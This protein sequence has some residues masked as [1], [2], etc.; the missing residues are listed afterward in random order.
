M[1]DSLDPARYANNGVDRNE[2]DR[3]KE[4]FLTALS[5]GAT[6]GCIL[7]GGLTI[8]VSLLSLWSS[9]KRTSMRHPF[10]E[11]VRMTLFL[12]SLSGIYVMVDEAIAAF[13]G[14]RRSG[15]P[16][17][18]QLCLRVCSCRTSSWRGFVAGLCAGPSLLFLGR[19]VQHNSLALYIFVRSLT[20]LIRCG[21]HLPRRHVLFSLLWPTRM[22]HGDVMLMCLSGSQILY[23][24]IM[25]PHTMPKSYR[26]FLARHTGREAYVWK[27]VKVLNRFCELVGAVGLSRSLFCRRWHC[28]RGVGEG[29]LLIVWW[30]YRGRGI[31]HST[32]PSPVHWC[33]QRPAASKTSF[34]FSFKH[35][36]EPCLFICQ[37]I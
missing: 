34:V 17:I 1:S 7:R 23:S 28:T 10:E 9:K 30:D 26:H 37:F 36:S 11:A 35:I 4:R 5:R 15:P 18:H 21:N 12:G 19:H 33:I 32:V 29:N 20:L 24:Y 27:T 8:F 16:E 25:M 3:I 31:C 22:Q 14:K 2:D 6:T 13:W